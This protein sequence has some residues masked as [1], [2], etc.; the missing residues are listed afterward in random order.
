MHTTMLPHEALESLKALAAD[1]LEAG[2]SPAMI[3][4]LQD[5]GYIE[6]VDGVPIVT[7][8]GQTVLDADD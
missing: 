4:I 1:G 2:I 6:I 8:A 3:K 7:E 5:H